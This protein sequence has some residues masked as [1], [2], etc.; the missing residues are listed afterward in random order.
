MT[1]KAMTQRRRAHNSTAPESILFN[2]VK[3]DGPASIYRAA[4]TPIVSLATFTARFR[5]LIKTGQLS[6]PQIRE[7]LNLSP[8]EFKLKYSTRRTYLEVDGER[9]DLLKYF[10]SAAEPSLVSYR[11]FWQRVR[12]LSLR[13]K[14]SSQ[15]LSDARTLTAAEWVS[16]YGGGRSKMF[17]YSGD[18]YPEHNGSSFHGISAFLRTIGRYDECSTIWSRLKAGWNLDAALSIPV[19][20]QSLRSGSIYRITRRKTGQVYVG[21]TITTIAQRWAFH[22]AAARQGSS[23]R[24]HQAIRQDG[25]EGFLIE[26]LEE[27][28]PEPEQLAARERCWVERLDCLGS[29]GLNTAKPGGLGSPSGVVFKYDGETFRSKTEGVEVLSQRSGVAPHAVRRRINQGKPI[30]AAD[31][32]RRH[33]KHKDAGSNLYRRWL[34]LLKRHKENVTAEWRSSYDRFKF[35]VS[36]VPDDMELV[37]KDELHPWGTSNFEWISTTEKLQRQHGKA[38]ELHG[39]T[40]P[41]LNALAAAYEIGVST[42]KDRIYRQGLT[43]EQA[44]TTKL[45]SSSYKQTASPV[46]VD[47]IEFRSK[48]QAILHIAETRGIT[49]HQAKYR[50]SID[51]Y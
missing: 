44:V 45:G 22:V 12:S 2:G 17:V 14:I 15:S 47:G 41:S 29:T 16:F 37:R 19:A 34:G 46:F 36:P 6:E 39:S 24:L 30:P 35:D 18:E 10:E 23:T 38:V 32:V 28:I 49:E 51:Q 50:F 21:L 42:L 13:G 48:R 11:N 3:H 20:F 9:I 27:G 1:E 26:A 5:R 7:C 40:Y 43:I 33:S 25:P 31:K 8:D 4:P